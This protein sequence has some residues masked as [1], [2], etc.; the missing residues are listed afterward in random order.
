MADRGS[1][2]DGCV[3]MMVENPAGK[4]ARCLTGAVC[5]VDGD[6]GIRNSLRV[7]LRTLDI[8]VFIFT[9]AEEFLVGLESGEPLFLITELS[10]PGITGFQLKEVLDHRKIPVPVLGLTDRIGPADRQR[11]LGLGFLDLV[12]KPFVYRPVLE[13]VQEALKR[14]GVEEPLAQ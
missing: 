9:T 13:R 5:V 3:G 8:P 6:H 2:R 7:L 10:L 11:A 12:E 14:R 1:P 4:T